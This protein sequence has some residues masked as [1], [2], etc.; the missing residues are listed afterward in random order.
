MA[1]RKLTGGKA[2]E[3]KLRSLADRVRRPAVLQVGFL[4]EATY[5]DGTPV[6]AVAAANEFGAT[7]TVPA[8]TVTI[9]ARPFFRSMIARNSPAWGDKVALALKVSGM[10]AATA[11]KLIGTELRDQLQASI[12]SN[13]PPPNAP[14]TVADKRR[15]HGGNIKTL[16][17]S[18]T[19]LRA[20]DFAVVK[21]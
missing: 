19:M 5:K 17:D 2:L 15:R 1:T 20:V 7:V 10:N 4:P 8:H 21:S 14:S 16:V 11:L 3:Q 6:A 13:V 12:L 18:G 9:P